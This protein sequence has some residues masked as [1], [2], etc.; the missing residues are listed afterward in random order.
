MAARPLRLLGAALLGASSSADKCGTDGCKEFPVSWWVWDAND[1]NLT[2]P[3]GMQP[4]IKTQ[5]GGHC[6]ALREVPKSE[7]RKSHGRNT[8]EWSE[9]AW[10]RTLPQNDTQRQLAAHVA[11]LEAQLPH[12]IPDPDFDGHAIF[13]YEE[14]DPVWEMNNCTYLGKAV[15]PAAFDPG[16]VCQSP[17]SG[18]PGSGWRGH[19][20]QESIAL[21]VSTTACR[22]C[23]SWAVFSHRCAVLQ[24]AKH[25]DWSE[26]QLVAQ[27]K[28]DFQNAV[29]AAV[30]ILISAS[31]NSLVLT[32]AKACWKIAGRL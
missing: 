8:S 31:T 14:W 10:P 22:R 12:C 21:V 13:D 27:A 28:S 18:V 1:T 2:A 19:V 16:G 7:Q 30:P 25:P 5:L 20:Q 3:W 4:L 6:S 11:A 17:P 32:C 24:R 15:Y 26:A 29:R 23:L 9:G